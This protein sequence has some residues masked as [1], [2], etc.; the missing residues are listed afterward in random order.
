MDNSQARDNF[1]QLLIEFYKTEVLEQ[2]SKPILKSYLKKK[3]EQLKIQLAN[4]SGVNI[5]LLVGQETIP[6]SPYTNWI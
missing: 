6:F 4:H 2:I 3:T 5:S 1:D